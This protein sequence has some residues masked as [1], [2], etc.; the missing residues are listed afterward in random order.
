MRLLRCCI[1]MTDRDEGGGSTKSS[2]GYVFVLNGGAVDWKSSKQT[3]LFIPLPV[4]RKEDIPEAELPPR[5][6]LCLTAPTSRY[7]VRESLTAAPRPTGGHRTDYG[8][9]GTMDAE[10]RRAASFPDEAWAHSVAVVFGSYTL[11]CQNDKNHTQM[12]G[13]P[14]RLTGVTDDDIDCTSFITTRIIVSG[15]GTDSGTSG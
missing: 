14:Y 10:I 8:F 12:P 13:L 1:L 6:R 11:N 4:D 15:I 7:E 2:E 5:K 3:L 9:I